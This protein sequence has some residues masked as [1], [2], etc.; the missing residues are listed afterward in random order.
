[1]CRPYIFSFLL[2]SFHGNK[3]R[4]SA[5]MELDAN[6]EPAR[7]IKLGSRVFDKAKNPQTGASLALPRREAR[8]LRRRLRRHTHRIQRIKSLLVRE[9]VITLEQSDTLFCGKLD[10][11]YMLRT[12]ALDTTFLIILPRFIIPYQEKLGNYNYPDVFKNIL[13]II[14]YQEKLGNYNPISASKCEDLIIPYQEKLGKPN[15]D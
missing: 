13:I 3:K 5:V 7:I 1:M 15:L 4:D 9:G 11:I 6:D 10:D 12:K 14:P 8:G 2:V